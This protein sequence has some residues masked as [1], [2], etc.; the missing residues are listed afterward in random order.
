MGFRRTQLPNPN[1]K[2]EASTQNNA[3]VDFG[4]FDQKLTGSAD[5]FFIR[6]TNILV[7]PPSLAVLGEGASRS[8]NG[9]SMENQ[10]FEALLTYNN[11][12]GD[13]RYSVSANFSSY[14]N[15]VT[16]LPNEVITQYPGNGIDKTILGRA[17]SSVFGYIT[18][19]IFKSQAEVDAYINQSGKGVGRLIYRDIGG[20]NGTGADGLISD[21][22]RDF[23]GKTDPDFTYGLNITLQYKQWDLTVFWNGVQGSYADVGSIKRNEQFIGAS[24]AAGQNYGKSTLNAWTFE[25]PNS[26][27]PRLS[28]RDVNAEKTRMSTYFL[29]NTSYLKL[30]NMEIGYTI[31]KAISSKALIQ[32]ARIY[33]MGDNLLKIYKKSGENAFTGAD[34]ETPGTAYPIPLSLTIGI[35]VTF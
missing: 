26:D 19:G 3:G 5:Y 18:D 1:L 28:L 16:S 7:T 10:G 34:P 27:I 30:R 23:I 29:E 11:K 2:W 6:T 17:R 4:L 20:P 24:E 13:F 15:K 32:N 8:V 9:A 25:N 14:R 35:N 31:P 33:M 21:A 22:D 12:T